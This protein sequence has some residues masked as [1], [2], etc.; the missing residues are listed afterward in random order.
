MLDKCY[1]SE[2]ARIVQYTEIKHSATQSNNV[3]NKS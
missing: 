2:N 1:V 3:Y